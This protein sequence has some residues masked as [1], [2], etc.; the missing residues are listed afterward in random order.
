[1][2]ETQPDLREALARDLAGELRDLAETIDGL[3]CTKFTYGAQLR[4]AAARA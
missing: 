2:S 4:D 3:D 1:M